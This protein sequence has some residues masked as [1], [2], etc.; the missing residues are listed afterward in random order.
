MIGRT[1]S[2]L[3]KLM[4]NQRPDDLL[5]FWLAGFFVLPEV[6]YKLGGWPLFFASIVVLLLLCTITAGWIHA[7]RSKAA[8]HENQSTDD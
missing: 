4:G 2:A 8:L 7:I 1:L 3:N 6:C 5:S